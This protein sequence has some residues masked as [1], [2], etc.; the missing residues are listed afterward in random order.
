MN[1]I[2]DLLSDRVAAQGVRDV[3]D[4]RLTGPPLPG[5]LADEVHKAICQAWRDGYA[6]GVTRRSAPDA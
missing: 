6:S 1:D 2:D 3:L 5:T 4:S